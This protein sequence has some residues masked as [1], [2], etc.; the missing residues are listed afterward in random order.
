[1]MPPMRRFVWVCVMLAVAGSGLIAARTTLGG[2]DDK[3]KGG[4]KPK[5][6]PPTRVKVD[7]AEKVDGNVYTSHKVQYRT[8]RMLWFASLDFQS[9]R[10]TRWDK[11]LKA[12]KP[13]K[14]EGVDF[15]VKGEARARLAR[16]PTFYEEAVAYVYTA[17]AEIEIEDGDKKPIAH[18]LITIERS[19]HNRDQA[20]DRILSSL[21]NYVSMTVV[22]CEAIRSR[23][24]EQR[25][26]ALKKTFDK[27]RKEIEEF[28]G[29]MKDLDLE[30]TDGTDKKGRK[31][32]RKKK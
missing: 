28:G 32:R 22:E 11:D 9:E 7:I 31:K 14:K 25:K 27:I 4:K 6:P 23:I 29:S 26:K 3:G 24:P 13:R 21:G 30:D 19:G 5:L 8:V 1:M 20:I 2:D 10:K 18:F 17:E 12:Y 16:R 15:V